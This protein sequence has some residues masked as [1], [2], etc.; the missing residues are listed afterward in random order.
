MTTLVSRKT[1]TLSDR[2]PFDIRNFI[3]R[4]TP[5]KGPN[6]YICP[7]CEGNNLTID[8][9]TSEYQCWSGC[10]CRDIREA[11]SPWN[12]VLSD[13]STRNRKPKPL[14]PAPIPS[15]TPKLAKQS[16]TA[17]LP[18]NCKR[19]DQTEI[20][21]PYSETQWVVRTENPADNAK[22]YEKITIPYHLNTDG[23]SVKGKGD[24]AWNPYRMNEVTSHGAGKWV[25]GVEGESC[26]EAARYL[27]LV[28]FTLQGS[29]WTED[30]L[31]RAM[32]QCKTAGV[33]GVAY[34]PD[35][36]KTGYKKAQKMASAAAKAQL[37][38]I[39]LNPLDIWANMPDKGDIADWVK[40]GMAQGWDKEEFIRRLEAEI[41][42]AVAA[43]IEAQKAN[44][45]DER[46][47]LELKALLKET[48][49]IKKIRRRSEI[50]SHYRIRSA[51]LDQLLKHLDE[52]SKAQKPR[53]MDLGELFDLHQAGVE[54]LIP[55]MLPVG[56]TV[57]LV[58][59]PK[60]GK[61]LLAYDAAFCVATGESDF[62]GERTGQGKVLI[63]Q[64]DESVNTARGRLLKRGF[65]REDKDNV[66]FVDSFNISQL[67]TLEEWLESFRPSL[68]IIDSLRRI[69]AGREVSENS[70]EFADT[71]YRLKELLTRYNAAGIL[72][73][74]SNKNQ[75][76]VGIQRVRGSTAIAGAVWGIWQLDHIP[77]PDPNNKKRM[78]IDPKD[79]TRTFSVTAR[80]TE[81]QRLRIELDPEN[82]HWVNLGEEGVEEA[83]AKERKTHAARILEL[84]KSVSPVGLEVCKINAELRIGRGIYSV[85]NR[86]L[87]QRTISSKSSSK[88]ARRTVYYYPKNEGDTPP[89]PPTDPNAIKKLETIDTSNFQSSITNRSQIDRIRSHQDADTRTEQLPIL[90]TAVISEI[91][92]IS[93]SQGGSECAASV[94][95]VTVDTNFTSPL[96]QE[97]SIDVADLTEQP[98]VGKRVLVCG[99]GKTQGEGTVVMD[100]GYGS[101]RMLQVRM[102]DDILQTAL[103]LNA[104]RLI[105][106]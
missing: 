102:D 105:D 20:K 36:D 86:M 5:A 59:D 44:D 64:C 88:D 78:I 69:N 98:L 49:P 85:L 79:P 84:L 60:A 4:L 93:D 8:P 43:R 58:A 67:D 53:Q 56:E 52:S 51:D 100:C 94:A 71:I 81:G 89:P 106:L 40:W 101:S 47:K 92:H 15:G 38:F 83:E 42:A 87:E 19:G 33:I 26:T 24:A 18:Q 39:E 23:E 13:R 73:H 25:L 82:N 37:P 17:E 75:D 16:E 62:L 91:D 28:G 21:Y 55:G 9:N 10:E 99:E 77:K 46:L 63:V 72:I 76:A 29:A 70:A 3:D 12:Q 95:E 1:E 7:V 66:R 6:R 32:L 54:Y 97:P 57:L 27:G 104:C 96:S 14:S 11:I 2:Q 90:D 31:T 103:S 80:D 41:H 22:G 68:V 34:F 50:A 30:D 48:D 45:P 35:H 74:H 61:S 65:R